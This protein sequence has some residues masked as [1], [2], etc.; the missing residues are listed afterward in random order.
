M[1]VGIIGAGSWGTAVAQLVASRGQTAWLYAEDPA[2]VAEI[3]E[4]H[5]NERRLPGVTLDERVQAT[6]ELGQVA[7]AAR[8][9]VLAVPSPRVAEV[10]CALGDVTDGRHLLV[11]AIGAPADLPGGGKL[12]ADLVRQETSM[13]RIGVL[14]GP[15]LAGDLAERRPCAVVC[16]S[17]FDEVIAA[18]RAS[19]ETPGVLRVYG[20]PDLAGVEISSALSGAM[21]IAIGLAD[22]LGLGGGPRAVLVCRALAEGTRLSVAAGARERTFAGLAG[23]GNLLARAGSD[24]SRDY[25][26]GLELARGHGERRETEGARAA[27]AAV[28]LGRRLNVRTPILDAVVGIVHEGLSVKEAATRLAGSGAEGE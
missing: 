22:G 24:L 13:K 4:R 18:T 11:H 3:N 28:K 17:H 20:S 10:V 14:A 12:V 6:H 25:R 15:A 26:L 27:A 2:I 23:L 16:A 21:T 1:S 9:L 8:L 7:T 5:T 19:L